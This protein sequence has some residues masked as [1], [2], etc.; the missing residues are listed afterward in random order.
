MSQEQ[1]YTGTS[2]ESFAEAA[3]N[4]LHD[5]P[6]DPGNEPVSATVTRLWLE[7]GGFVGRT[8]YRVE[9]VPGRPEDA[10]GDGSASP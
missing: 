10:Y 7:R 3:A 5:I 9:I 8:Q 1:R 4:A 6:G 2:F